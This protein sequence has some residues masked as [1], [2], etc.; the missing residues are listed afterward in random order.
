MRRVILAVVAT[1]A[2]AG[3]AAPAYAGTHHSYTPCVRGFTIDSGGYYFIGHHSG[4]RIIKQQPWRNGWRV[5][6]HESHHYHYT[7]VVW[8]RCTQPA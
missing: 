3:I 5:T 6:V 2:M 4:A 8:A 1:L 7:L